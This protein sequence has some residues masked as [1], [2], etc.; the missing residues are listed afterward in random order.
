MIVECVT[1]TILLVA[2]FFVFLRGHK[3]HSALSTVPLGLVPVLHLLGNPLSRWLSS[4]LGVSRLSVYVAIDIAA[5]ALFVF[6]A[7][8]VLGNFNSK[9]TKATY[10]IATGLF[11]LVLTAILVSDLFTRLV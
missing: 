6:V 11:E 5:F 8:V 10:L 2:I 4:L 9:R 7:V 3:P 1:I